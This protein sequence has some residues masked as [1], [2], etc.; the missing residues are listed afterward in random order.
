MNNKHPKLFVFIE[1]SWRSFY[2]V[3][4]GKKSFGGIDITEFNGIICTT[5]W[6]F[7]T[8]EFYDFP[9]SWEWNHHPNCYSLSPS[10]FRWVGLNHQADFLHDRRDVT[11]MDQ[12]LVSGNHHPA[13]RFSSK[14]S[15]DISARFLLVEYH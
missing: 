11:G 8:M 4:H 1:S 5:G 12:K 6:W 14:E 10:F 7:G 9:F 13:G 2:E 15:E 3:F